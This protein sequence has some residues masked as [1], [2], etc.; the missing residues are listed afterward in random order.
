GREIRVKVG[1]FLKGA[2]RVPVFSDSPRSF[3][4]KESTMAVEGKLE[5]TIKMPRTTRGGGDDKRP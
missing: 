4:T 5:I 3:Q 2:W 1:A